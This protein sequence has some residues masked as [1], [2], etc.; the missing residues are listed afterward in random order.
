MQVQ[1]FNIF[2]FETARKIQLLEIMIANKKTH[3]CKSK[4]KKNYLDLWEKSLARATIF[5]WNNLYSV[6][7]EMK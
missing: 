2:I 7:N 6:W 4:Q 1:H 5:I 3:I